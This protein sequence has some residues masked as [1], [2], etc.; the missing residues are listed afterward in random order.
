[1]SSIDDARAFVFGACHGALATRQGDGSPFAS[2]INLVADNSGRILFLVSRL[3][4]HAVNLDHVAD[5]SLLLINRDEADWQAAPR[6]SLTGSVHPVS[7]AEGARYLALFPHTREYLQLDFHFLAFEISKARWI[8]GF[9][10]ACWLAG[11][12]VG[13]PIPFDYP[14][15]Q[16]MVA[17]MNDDHADALTHYLALAGWSGQDVTLAALDPWGMW[18]IVDGVPRRYPFPARA[19]DAAAVR[20]TLVALARR[21]LPEPGFP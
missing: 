14:H 6:M 19:D 20:E 10:K 13:F 11:E 4:E 3:A 18:L 2:A 8:P 17:H 1:M 16:R 15:E 7:E 21:E 9:A 5:C 12:D